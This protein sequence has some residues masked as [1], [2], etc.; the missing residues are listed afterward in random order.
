MEPIHL[1][2]ETYKNLNPSS[3]SETIRQIKSGRS[4]TTTI[5]G[6]AYLIDVDENSELVII[7]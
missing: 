3:K 4:Y 1:D 6:I 2:Y 5:E 7:D